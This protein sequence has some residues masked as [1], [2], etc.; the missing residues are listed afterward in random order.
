CAAFLQRNAIFFYPHRRDLVAEIERLAA[1]LG[2]QL[3]SPRLPPKY[4]WIRTAFGWRLAKRIH[5]M[6]PEIRWS[7]VSRWDKALARVEVAGVT[8]TS[9]PT[10]NA[11]GPAVCSSRRRGIFLV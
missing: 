5:M 3:D 10:D 4:D 7:L 6:G 11:G 2:K 1:G 9:M 8:P